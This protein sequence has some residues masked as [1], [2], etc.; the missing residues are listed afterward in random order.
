[1]FFEP[2][3]GF[4]RAS[5]SGLPLPSRTRSFIALR[6]SCPCSS[7]EQKMDACVLTN[8]ARGEARDDFLSSLGNVCFR[9]LTLSPLV[10]FGSGFLFVLKEAIPASK[11]RASNLKSDLWVFCPLEPWPRSC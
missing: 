2:F 6:W 11:G 1:M 8:K 7:C 4:Q 5:Q 9:G 10:V 3:A